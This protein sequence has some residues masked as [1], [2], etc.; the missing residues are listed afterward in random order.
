MF[1]SWNVQLC[2]QGISWYHFNIGSLKLV[3]SQ[4]SFDVMKHSEEDARLLLSVFHS[5]QASWSLCKGARVWVFSISWKIQCFYCLLTNKALA[6]RVNGFI[7]LLFRVAVVQHHPF[8]M[9]NPCLIDRNQNRK[10]VELWNQSFQWNRF[11][12]LVRVGVWSWVLQS[13]RGVAVLTITSSSST[14]ACVPGSFSCKYLPAAIAISLQ[15]IF[16]QCWAETF[17]PKVLPVHTRGTIFRIHK[18]DLPVWKMV[19]VGAFFYQSS[20]IVKRKSQVLNI[21]AFWASK[22]LTIGVALFWSSLQ[23]AD[24]GLTPWWSSDVHASHAGHHSLPML[25]VHSLR[26][27]SAPADYSAGLPVALMKLSNCSASAVLASPLGVS[28]SNNASV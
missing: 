11:P 14:F 5:R 6:W 26:G 8:C 21:R 16:R 9:A 24:V 1:D 27:V 3:N 17:Q 20:L 19:V 23:S 4:T 7:Q 22:F 18:Q 2:E 28:L 10:L 25:T 12:K 13:L 15:W